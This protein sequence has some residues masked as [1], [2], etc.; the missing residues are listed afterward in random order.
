MWVCI[1]ACG[2]G[3]IV[4]LSH[5]ACA[6]EAD[7]CSS[8][9]AVSPTFQLHNHLSSPEPDSPG[10]PGTQC[11]DQ[12][13]LPPVCWH[14]T[15]H[16]LAFSTIVSMVSLPF[17]FG[18]CFSLYSGLCLPSAGVQDVHQPHLDP[19]RHKVSDKL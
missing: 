1:G 6:L 2:A 10:C 12:A 9:R 8:A 16:V 7:L 13:G 11:V 15:S 4:F 14:D 5:L 19:G 3:V 18:G 17:L